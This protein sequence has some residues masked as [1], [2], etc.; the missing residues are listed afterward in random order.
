MDGSMDSTRRRLRRPLVSA[1][2]L[3]CL[4]LAASI[5]PVVEPAPAVHGSACPQVALFVASTA[6]APRGDDS[7][8]GA[9]EDRLPGCVSTVSDE[10]ITAARAE[11]ADLVI[12]SSSVVTTVLR[13][14]LVDV[15]TPILVAE[16][17][18]FDDMSLTARN[19]RE[20]T[21]QTALQVTD[22]SHPLAGGLSGFVAVYQSPA[23]MNY[24]FGAASGVEP[25]A[26]S[27]GSSQ[28]LTIFGFEAEAG[29]D[30]AA[31]I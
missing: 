16:P 29:V 21:G 23:R 26:S 27:A 7:F 6:P 15:G 4:A 10:S 30:D 18:L 2:A 3:T 8:L 25:V 11:A 13:D 20:L 22:A 14:R 1:A 31:R 17:Y 24:A 12:I 19:G 9:V 5:T 28:Q